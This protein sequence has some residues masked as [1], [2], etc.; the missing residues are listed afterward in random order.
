MGAL[1]TESATIRENTDAPF[2]GRDLIFHG[3][4]SL[5][6]IFPSGVSLGITTRKLNY[7]IVGQ[8]AP[9]PTEPTSDDTGTTQEQVESGA[10]LMKS[11]WRLLL[12]LIGLHFLVTFLRP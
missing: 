7:F 3:I 11:C 8:E 12:A 2:T 4:S 1:Y 10:S 6:D 9:I 5:P